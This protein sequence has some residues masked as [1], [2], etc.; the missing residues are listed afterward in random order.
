MY[1][2]V[3]GPGAGPFDGGPGRA[4][5]GPW[6]TDLELSRMG[7]TGTKI[8]YKLGDSPANLLINQVVMATL[9]ERLGRLGY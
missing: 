6:Q 8:H 4:S 3:P 5:T 1:L 2:R 9:Q 7:V